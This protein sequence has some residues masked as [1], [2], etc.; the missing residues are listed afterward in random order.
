MRRAAVIMTARDTVAYIDAAVTSVLASAAQVAGWHVHLLIA[1]DACEET[2]RQLLSLDRPHWYAQRRVGS[3][4]LRNSLA[5]I[6]LMNDEVDVILNFDSDDV[7]LP[8]YLPAL[9]E[10]CPRD[11]LA[12]A[13]RFEVGAQLEQEQPPRIKPWA[14]VGGNCAIGIEAW[15]RLG[16]YWTEHWTAMDTELCDRARKGR[17]PWRAVETPLFLRRR[18]PRSMT[19]G[20]ATGWGSALRAAAVGA[21]A[22]RREA[23]QLVY[24]DPVTCALEVRLP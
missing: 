22:A 4:V 2:S 10:A 12:G 19:Q 6:A 24:V 8:L 11:G 14:C 13:A 7:M 18:N 5:A 15:R 1:V 3:F 20:Y 21:I 23:Q 9:L 16:G 17:M